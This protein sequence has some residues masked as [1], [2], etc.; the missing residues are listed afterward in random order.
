MTHMYRVFWNSKKINQQC[1][2][3]SS[4]WRLPWKRGQISCTETSVV[5][6]QATPEV[7][8]PQL[9]RGRALNIAYLKFSE[10]VASIFGVQETRNII[11]VAATFC[12]KN[13]GIYFP[14]YSVSYP[15]RLEP[16]LAS[17]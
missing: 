3:R 16:S 2:V 17:L 1:S 15:R 9:H 14:V 7:R 6:Y 10:L 13:V 4:E 11:N 8:A 5:N 12:F